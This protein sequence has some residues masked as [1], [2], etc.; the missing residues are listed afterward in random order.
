MAEKLSEMT[1]RFKLKMVTFGTG[2]LEALKNIIAPEEDEE[3]YHVYGSALNPATAAGREKKEIAQPNV[4]MEVKTY[5]REKT[6]GAPA[7]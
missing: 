7:E 4:K 3:D 6:G 1:V 2:E 5:N